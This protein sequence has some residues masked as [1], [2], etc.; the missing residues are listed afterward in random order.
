MLKHENVQLSDWFGLLEF[1]LKDQ[2]RGMN[3]AK[4]IV[5]TTHI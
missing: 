2:G 1:I 4:V 5:P 3:A